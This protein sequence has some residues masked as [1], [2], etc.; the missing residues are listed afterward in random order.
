MAHYH[1]HNLWQH[2]AP[3][4][5]AAPALAGTHEAD[6]VIVG[7]GFTGCSAALHAAEQGLDV[8]LLEANTI[9]HGG[10]GRNVGLVNAG[11]WMP[12][13]DIEQVLGAAAG[14]KLNRILAE[15]P[16]L[17]FSLIEQHDIACNA[18][19]N[20]TLHCAHSARGRE[21]LE[22]RL[23]QQQQRSAPVTLLDAD[24]THRRTGAEGF[25]GALFDRRAGT[26][27][28]LAYCRGLA[29]AATAAGAHLHEQ[30]GVQSFR[31][32][33]GAWH[34]TTAQGSVRARRLLVATN[35][36]HEVRSNGASPGL[37]APTFTPVHFFQFATRPL[38][39]ERLAQILPG[40]EG[41]WDTGT[42]MSAFR[43]DAAGRLVV[44]SIGA[45]DHAGSA[46]HRRWARRKLASLFPALH[47]E[48]FE[49]A[50]HGRIA[51]TNDHLPRIVSP[52]E[53]ALMIFG[54]SGRGIGPGTACGRYAAQALATGDHEALPLSPVGHYTESVPRLREAF[55]E[56]GALVDHAGWMLRRMVR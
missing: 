10:S 40:G 53:D 7:G 17:V 55:F 11:L 5:F 45:L 43:R 37:A 46:L 24:E 15:A 56:C 20:G 48:P 23:A 32:D 12:P 42:V 44:G 16:A 41:C 4:T 8:C 33:G 2:T 49:Y 28:P 38:A 6:L 47:A 36:Y 14:G 34:V 50:W 39:A 22:R 51:M 1:E 52:G 35:A 9:G 19:R 30:S 27:E 54:Y 26:I 13:D 3:E 21:E 29:R 25:H 18:V 31:R